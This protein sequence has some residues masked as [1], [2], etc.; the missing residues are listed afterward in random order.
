M[1]SWPY[2]I[3]IS[4]WRVGW[5]VTVNSSDAESCSVLCTVTFTLPYVQYLLAYQYFH[6][7]SQMND[8][9]HVQGAPCSD[10]FIWMLFNIILADFRDAALQIILQ[11]LSLFSPR[12]GMAGFEGLQSPSIM[13]SWWYYLPSVQGFIQVLR[14]DWLQPLGDL[15]ISNHL[16]LESLVINQVTREP[17]TSDHKLFELHT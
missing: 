9:Q 2:C 17:S 15:L 4:I 6:Q 16:M 13:V 14:V 1:Q 8:L 7:G 10:V 3:N 5:R 12:F 11:T